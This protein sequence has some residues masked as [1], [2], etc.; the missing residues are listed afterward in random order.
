MNLLRHSTK[1]KKTQHQSPDLVFSG[2][3]QH[4]FE[5]MLHGFAY[6]RVIFDDN[7]QVQDFEYIYVNKTYGSFGLTGIPGKRVLE[8]V[9]GMRQ[10]VP[11]LFEAVQRVMDSGASE[12][13]EQ[14]IPVLNKWFSVSV[15]S[16]QPGYFVGF[17]DDITQHKESEAKI[18][19][20]NRLY[21]FI[22]QIN[23]AIV[24][25][26][27]QEELFR[28][29]CRIAFESGAFEMAWIG[30]ID[31][32]N[33]S[34]GMLEECGMPEEDRELFRYVYYQNGGPQDHIVCTG[35]SF[36]CN[37]IENDFPLNSWKPYAEVRG[38]HSCM[39]LP[40]KKNGVVY[41]TF[42]LYSSV[43]HF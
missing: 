34:I 33:K 42:N 21:A 30:Q 9:P 25:T 29:T 23:Q 3:Y 35:T 26:K 36:I 2:A 11:Q 13:F 8:I 16:P 14:Y 24:Y 15:Y 31:R 5:N 43:P 38:L 22:S 6:C 28:K 27:D 10:Q 37:H 32:E 20:L 18:K 39:V 17:L 12:M 7:R 4:L 1:K 40:F 41:A 19:K